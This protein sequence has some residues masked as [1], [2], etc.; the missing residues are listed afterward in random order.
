MR[1][2]RGFTRQAASHC[3]KLHQTASQVVPSLHLGAVRGA[4]GTAYR[5]E[6]VDE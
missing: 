5:F 3:I 1:L 2:A 4:Y 6:I